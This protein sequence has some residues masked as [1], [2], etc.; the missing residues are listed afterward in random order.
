MPAILLY[1]AV[2]DLVLAAAW[3]GVI[4]GLWFAWIIFRASTWILTH[5]E[6]VR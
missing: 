3:A 4:L 2:I 5:C 6:V 1:V